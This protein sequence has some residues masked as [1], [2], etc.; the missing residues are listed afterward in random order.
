MRQALLLAIFAACLVPQ[1]AP[2]STPPGDLDFQILNATLTPTDPQTVVSGALDGLFRPYRPH[3]KLPRNPTYWVKVGP[4]TAMTT[5]PLPVLVAST[6]RNLAIEFFTSR[7]GE[8]VPVPFATGLP[9]FLGLED[10]IFVLPGPLS[11]DQPLYGRIQST[12]SDVYRLGFSVSTLPEVLERS[13]GRSR[14]ITLA[15]GALIAVSIAALLIWFVLSDAL[16]ILYA[17]LFSLQALYIAYFSGQ[18]FDWPFL[19]LAAPLGSNTWNVP[20]ALSGAVG[21]LFVREI[22]DLQRSSPRHYKV[23]GWLAVAFGVLAFANIAKMFGYGG[24][25]NALGN[26][27]FLGG[28]I[29]TVIVASL[30]WRRGNH[31]AGWFLVAW[32]LLEVFTVAATLDLLLSNSGP[33]EGLLYYG[34]PLSMVAASVLMA[35]GVADR[36]RE[37]RHALTQA[38]FHAQTDP[39]TGVLN[40][41]SLLERLEAGCGRARARGMPIALLFIDLDHFKRIN[42]SHGHPAGDACLKAIIDP[43]QSELRQSDVIGRYGGEEFVVVL[44]SADTAV[45]HAIAARILGRV[46]EIRVEGFGP[47]IHLTCSIGV[48]GSDRLGVWNEQL[49]AHADA[50]VYA[51]KNS[52]RNRVQVAT[53]LAA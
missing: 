6:S 40:R 4:A 41:R 46:A 8:L 3:Q 21:C 18:A 51:A 25:V 36:L 16:F 34:L 28:A 30:A 35:L 43:I 20:I 22:A 19:S 26:I 13:T 11:A 42:D 1:A 29:Y 37:Q 9:Q 47:P 14:M 39:L 23:F 5:A 27:V 24:L 48:A 49:I 7:A 45:A 33:T 15:F 10:A 44:S 53:P 52:G 12:P 31:A 17:A 38:Q 50:A 2:A 32:S